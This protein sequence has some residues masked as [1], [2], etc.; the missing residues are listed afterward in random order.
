MNGFAC[1]IVLMTGTGDYRRPVRSALAEGLR[2]L[3]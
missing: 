3:A 1:D 2:R